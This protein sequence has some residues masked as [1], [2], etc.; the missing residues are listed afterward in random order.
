[1]SERATI[2]MEFIFRA[3]PAILYKFMTSPDCLIRWYCDSADV[4]NDIF[5]FTWEGYDEKAILI[6]DIEE[7][8]LKF[9]WL[10]SENDQEYWEM[11]FSKSEVTNETI[12][13][14][15]DFCDA[16]EVEENRLIWQNQLEQ[17]RI[18]TGG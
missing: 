1:M 6:D 11:R 5:T 13:E 7:E 10:E 2:E 18:V 17:L 15:T 4:E 12:L 8:R 14:V 9:K 16:N 3:S